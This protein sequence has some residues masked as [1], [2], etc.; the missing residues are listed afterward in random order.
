MIFDSQTEITDDTTVYAQW[1]LGEIGT[2]T[3]DNPY[4][5]PDLETLKAFRNYVNAG[6][7]CEG[8]YF[9]VTNNI[10][11][12][13]DDEE[14]QW[15]PIGNKK[16]KR[17]HGSFNG[18]GYTISGLYINARSTDPQG[19]FGFISGATVKNLT[20]S[21]S[22]SSMQQVGGIAGHADMISSIE[23]CTNNCD[24]S[25]IMGSAGGIAGE[26]SGGS[27]ITGCCNNGSASSP[28][29]RA[30]GIA[31]HMDGFT[32]DGTVTSVIDSYNTGTI[33]GSYAGG[34]AGDQYGGGAVTNC[35]NIGTVTGSD[36]GGIVGDESIEVTN[37][38]YI[39]T[40][41]S[42]IP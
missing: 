4:L 12:A 13:D 2:T 30:G 19:L 10:D 26:C 32:T 17:F 3:E 11:L 16:E 34:I 27:K 35:Y 39:D 6:N 40:G 33:H 29:A 14:T 31:G 18:D 38:Y 9:K 1:K 41:D 21:G 8:M 23:N 28:S 15:I 5:I 20:V 37:C 7:T 25:S 42:E 24:V 22:V 36:A